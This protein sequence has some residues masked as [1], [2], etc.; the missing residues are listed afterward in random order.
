MRPSVD[1]SG[2]TW[3]RVIC[4]KIAHFCHFFCLLFVAS[5]ELS[6]IIISFVCDTLSKSP[7]WD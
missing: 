6:E 5:V 2:L 1:S 3:N 4:R 7:D